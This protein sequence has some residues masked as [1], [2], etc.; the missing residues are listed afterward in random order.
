MCSRFLCARG[1][2]VLQSIQQLCNKYGTSYAYYLVS[3]ANV[4]DWLCD[5]LLSPDHPDVS[6]FEWLVLKSSV[7][8]MATTQEVLR[9]REGHQP[10]DAI[11]VE[12]AEV[13]GQ[14]GG[15]AIGLS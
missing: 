13:R 12:G 9:G 2:V 4:A 1:L 14:G 6:V 3:C 8:D 11:M 15:G 5:L 7:Q 10:F